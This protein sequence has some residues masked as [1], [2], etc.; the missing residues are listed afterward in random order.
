MAIAVSA[1]LLFWYELSIKPTRNEKIAYSQ[2]DASIQLE[3]DEIL[4]LI[5][6]KYFRKIA[7]D[8]LRFL[9]YD[10]I[11][12]YL[13]QYSEY[14]TPEDNKAFEAQMNG[15]FGGFGVELLPTSDG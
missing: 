11:F 4:G 8:S 14:I 2:T 5:A 9:S 7:I 12:S 3:R 10:S 6:E 13:D 15:E 1:V